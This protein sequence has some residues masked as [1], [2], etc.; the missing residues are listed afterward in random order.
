MNSNTPQKAASQSSSI[1]SKSDAQYPSSSRSTTSGP[2]KPGTSVAGNGQD[3]ARKDASSPANA[4]LAAG[5]GG[6]TQRDS[7]QQGGKSTDTPSANED[8]GDASAEQAID[9]V[10]KDAGAEPS[11]TV[12]PDA[13][14]TR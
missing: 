13:S 3:G 4:T 6:D 14:S 11:T 9:Q 5:S 1:T 2:Q 12:R 10:R 8:A 7:A